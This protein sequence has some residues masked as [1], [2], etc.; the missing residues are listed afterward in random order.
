[1][2]FWI[3]E[4]IKKI[5]KV[6]YTLGRAREYYVNFVSTKKPKIEF[7]IFQHTVLSDQDIS[8]EFQGRIYGTPRQ[9]LDESFR[10]NQ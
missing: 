7:S 10:L 6:D 5:L 4:K 3:D 9:S 2:P 1:M 8:P